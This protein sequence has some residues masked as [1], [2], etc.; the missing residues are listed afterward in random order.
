M[1]KRSPYCV[2]G[3]N[4]KTREDMPYSDQD[5]Q[6]LEARLADGQNQRKTCHR[7][8]QRLTNKT[9]TP[10]MKQR[11]R[12]PNGPRRN[13]EEGGKKLPGIRSGGSDSAGLPCFSFGDCLQALLPGG[14]SNG[15]IGHTSAP[16]RFKLT[17]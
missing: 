16:G 2:S 11:N 10:M 17:R 14:R 5:V 8:G 3:T 12:R 15:T 4:R 1:K 7:Y 6:Y 9:S 13:A